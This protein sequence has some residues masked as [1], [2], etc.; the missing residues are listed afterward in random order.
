MAK[1]TTC[2]S[3]NIETIDKLKKVADK[4]NR[5]MANMLEVL[6][7]KAYEAIQPVPAQ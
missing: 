3:L 7:Q 2:F 4:D 1:K 5:S 6:I